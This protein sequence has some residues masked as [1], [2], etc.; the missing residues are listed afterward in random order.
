MGLAVA[1][2][3]AREIEKRALSPHLKAMGLAKRFLKQ[4]PKPALAG[5]KDVVKS[6]GQNLFS[7]TMDNARRGQFGTSAVSQGLSSA[8]K[9][10]RHAGGLKMHGGTSQ[11]Q[12]MVDKRVSNVTRSGLKETPNISKILAPKKPTTP[13]MPRTT[14]TRPTGPKPP[15]LKTFGR[16]GRGSAMHV[17]RPK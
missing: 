7:K 15:T 8:H 11:L 9:A 4:S 12:G 17:T 10:L 16:L 13:K 5:N 14:I 2:G 3:M 1:I 6:L